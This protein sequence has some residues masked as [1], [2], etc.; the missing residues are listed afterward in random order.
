MA[1]KYTVRAITDDKQSKNG[2]GYHRSGRFW[3]LGVEVES[4]KV[5]EGMLAD[6]NLVIVKLGGIETPDT[7][8]EAQVEA[9]V[10]SPDE[11]VGEA[12]SSIFRQLA[13]AEKTVDA[14]TTPQETVKPTRRRSRAKRK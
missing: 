9:P 2:P 6:P 7:P 4:D 1:D 3:P 13:H 11:H 10:A 8:V 14:V 5:S 12:T